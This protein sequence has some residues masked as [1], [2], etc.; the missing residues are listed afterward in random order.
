MKK[1]LLF[2][3]L[4]STPI[5]LSGCFEGYVGKDGEMLKQYLKPEDLKTLVDNPR[6]NIW[7]VDV[8]PEASYKKGYIPTSKNF[9]SGEIM[10]RLNEIPETKYLILACETGGRAQLVAKKLEKRGYTRF[11]N[12]GATS[13]YTD[14]YGSEKKRNK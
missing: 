12:W 1:I 2:M 14:I 6:E 9:P 3:V 5:F 10:N 4:L 8:R 7:I 13:R 11:M